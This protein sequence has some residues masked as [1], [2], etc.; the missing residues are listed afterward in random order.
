MSEGSGAAAEL[1]NEAPPRHVEVKMVAPNE[2]WPALQAVLS[3]LLS[4]LQVTVHYGSV[5]SVNAHQI[6]N[7]HSDDPPSVAR[8]WIDMRDPS[9]VTLFLTGAHE[10]RVLVRHVPLVSRLDEVAR[11]EIAH[12]VEATVEALLVGGRIDIV[13]DETFHKPVKAEP[14]APP[15]GERAPTGP[16]LDLAI[17]YE[18]QG[19]SSSESLLHSAA[20]FVGVQARSGTFRPGA[21]VSGEYRFPTTIEGELVSARLDQ[22]AFR[23]VATVDWAAAR[24]WLLGVGVGGGVDLVHVSPTANA[25]A[26][27]A[28]ADPYF[29]VVPMLR[30]MAIGRY[31]LT[32]R[33]D[34]F[35][36]I[37]V[38][39]DLLG[40]RYLLHA[41]PDMP[42]FQPW[43]MRPMALIGVTSD[44]LAH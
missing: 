35:A 28:Q 9:R 11:E 24:R 13:S 44:V 15:V 8:I 23:A 3:E 6:L 32:I 21:W 43:R 26:R 5:A 22:G 39:Y 41:R 14:V 33:S 18:A 29:A 42:V 7:E 27:V 25:G 12:I 17:A 30:S 16:A 19:W 31:A 20:L 37:A 10:D 40:T 1:A 36:G 34:L 38:D 4:R 2:S